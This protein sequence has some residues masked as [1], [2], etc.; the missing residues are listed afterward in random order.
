MTPAIV[1]KITALTKSAS[2][3]LAVKTEATKSSALYSNSGYKMT[4]NIDRY[5]HEGGYLK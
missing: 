1:S 3:P 4:A 2:A 5:P